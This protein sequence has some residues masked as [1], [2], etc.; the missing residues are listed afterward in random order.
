[1]NKYILYFLIVSALSST[2]H[3]QSF[4]IIKVK[5]ENKLIYFF[6]KGLKSDTLYKAKNNLFYLLVP[7]TLKKT[8]LLNIEN[9]QIVKTTNDSIVK[10]N[11]VGGLSYDYLF[12]PDRTILNPG[13]TVVGTYRTLISGTSNLTPGKIRIKVV[14]SQTLRIIYEMEFWYSQE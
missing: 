3:A 8:I 14:N 6:Q 11:Y 10:V 1:M 13:Q 5:K 12:E 2:L 9:G 4:D 7:D